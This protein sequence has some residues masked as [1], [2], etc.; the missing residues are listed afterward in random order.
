MCDVE[1]TSQNLCSAG[2]PCYCFSHNERLS[3]SVRTETIA[4]HFTA[5]T[6]QGASWLSHSLSKAYL[7]SA[8]HSPCHASRPSL[9]RNQRI[10]SEPTLSIHQAPKIACAPRLTTATTDNQPHVM[11]STVSVLNAR[12]PSRSA[13][14]IFLVARYRMIGIASSVTINP[15]AENS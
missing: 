10:A 6:G 9:I 3:P 4:L 15:D 14:S 12:L 11:D 1:R 5:D 13:R 2:K 8:Q 7:Q